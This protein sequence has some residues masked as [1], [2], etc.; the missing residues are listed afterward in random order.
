M[1]DLQHARAP[2]DPA[3]QH[4][5]AD[6]GLRALQL[7]RARAHLRRDAPGARATASARAPTRR[8]STCCRARSP[9]LVAGPIAGTVGR[10]FG[11]K[12]PL[13]AGCCSSAS[14]HSCSRSCT[15]SPGTVLLASALL[16]LGVGSAFASMAAPDR[17][18]R[19]PTRDGRRDRHEHR[20]PHHRRR[21]RRPG[22]R[23]GAHRP[24]IG[25]SSIPAESAY[26]LTFGLS[27]V[28]ALVAAAIAVSISSRPHL[29][30]LQVVAPPAPVS[31]AR[32]SPVRPQG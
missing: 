13:A 14:P 8:G 31:S 12:W 2:A 1:V 5:D 18:Q 22:G 24:T 21:G 15:T 32:T 17:R 28:T 27:A 19:R 10:R 4:R 9:M 29:R 6:L 26:T 23:V 3:H 20:R 25:D 11:S 7:L 30:H 16:G